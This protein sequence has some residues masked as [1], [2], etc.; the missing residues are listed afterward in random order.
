L[1]DGLCGALAL[2]CNDYEFALVNKMTGW[3]A[4]DMLENNPHMFIVVTRGEQGAT[5]YSSDEIHHI[6]VVP[7]TQIVDPTGV[8][9]AFRGGFLTGYGHCL[10]LATCGH[11]GAL[12]A[13]YCLEQSGPQ[14]HAYSTYEFIQRYRT[15]FNDDGKLDIF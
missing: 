5:I 9:D 7:P 6:P 11:L 8:G 2:F 14:G 10:D 12:A 15:L 1:R 3:D 4:G 13:A